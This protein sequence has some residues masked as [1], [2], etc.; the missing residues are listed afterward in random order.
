MGMVKKQDLD[1]I[2][3]K[4]NDRMQ[5]IIDWFWSNKDWIFEE[6]FHAPMDRGLIVLEEDNID[7]G[8]DV[9]MDG[10]V[11][12]YLYLR[13]M[14]HPF[15]KWTYDPETMEMND[16]QALDNLPKAKR[17]LLNAFLIVDRTDEKV[18]I[19]F[20]SLMAFA[21]Y[22]EEIIEV[23]KKQEVVRTKHEA[24]LLRKPGRPLPLTKKTYV[25]RDFDASDI[26]KHGEKRHYTK[27]DHEVPVR[28]YCRKGRNGKT[29]WVKPFSRYK[30]QGKGNGR[31]EYLA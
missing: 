21:V 31:K 11:D 29:V 12:L 10:K 4:K 7:V 16:Y 22:Y 8:F 19:R 23:D 5:E 1:R 25:V 14:D 2:I 17:E 24:K 18:A 30:N 13:K 15:I 26:H 28:G 20:H 3:V 6:G 9:R 27:P